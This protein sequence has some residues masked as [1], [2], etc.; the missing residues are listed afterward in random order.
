MDG[1]G[2]VPDGRAQTQGKPGFRDE[3]RGMGPGD[4]HAEHL[5]RGPVRNDLEHAGEFV[6]GLR[7]AEFAHLER[8]R[9]HIAAR[10]GSLRFGKPHAADFGRR[11][12]TGRHGGIVHPPVMP[13]ATAH[14]AQA[15]DGG[16]MGQHDFGRPERVA[17]GIHAGEGGAHVIVGPYPA[18]P[19]HG[20]PGFG[21]PEPG[22]IGRAPHRDQHG[23]GFDGR[24]LHLRG[25]GLLDERRRAE[26]GPDHA[27]LHA[28]VLE[29]PAQF[30][31][32]AAFLHF[33]LEQRAHI[34]IHGRQGQQAVL[35]FHHRD[36]GPE[37]L[38]DERQLAADNAPAHDGDGRGHPV[39]RQR[40][41]AGQNV[42]MI[43]GQAGKFQRTRTGPSAVEASTSPAWT[44]RPRPL[45]SRTPR[46][47]QAFSSPP[48]RVAQTF[49][50]RA[51]TA[52]GSTAGTPCPVMPN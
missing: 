48:R 34:R 16:D 33:P 2:D 7:L 5:T 31:T 37:G 14:G 1:C 30:A 27:A 17:H 41:V 15:L 40:V 23:F 22:G 49:S 51:S 50:L 52:A 18:P 32:D 36:L 8:G 4:M 46:L 44:R 24:F 39:E 20:D 19:V 45:R 11:E 28:H 3:I 12:N 25:R 35:S 43:D 38:I 26:R 13:E 21:Q 29:R 10:L 6:H 47:A 9:A 42:R